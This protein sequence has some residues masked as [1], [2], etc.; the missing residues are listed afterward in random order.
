[1]SEGW[2]VNV[3]VYAMPSSL[4]EAGRRRRAEGGRRGVAASR[5]RAAQHRGIKRR[6]SLQVSAQVPHH[7]RNRR[8]GRRQ[9]R[10]SSSH[11][12]QHSYIATV[13]ALR[14]KDDHSKSHSK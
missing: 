8:R 4:M 9:C 10:C 13:V 6:R 2:G 7:A 1:M 5:W 11:T 3:E 12:Q 14:R